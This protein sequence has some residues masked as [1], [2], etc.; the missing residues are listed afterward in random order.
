VIRVDD[1][2]SMRIKSISSNQVSGKTI[3]NPG[4]HCQVENSEILLVREY[5]HW[6]NFVL[7]SATKETLTIDSSRELNELNE[8]GKLN[9]SRSCT[10]G[11]GKNKTKNTKD[12]LTK[13]L[14]A[15]GIKPQCLLS[16]PSPDISFRTIAWFESFEDH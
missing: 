11:M 7:R 10:Q 6:P 4:T 9:R 13:Q 14:L 8:L 16:F 1:A 2:V 15:C 12:T 3:N 5:L